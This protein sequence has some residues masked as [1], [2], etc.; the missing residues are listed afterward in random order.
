MNK[1]KLHLPKRV[2]RSK[3]VVKRLEHGEGGGGGGG[4]GEFLGSGLVVWGGWI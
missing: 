3:H 2:L 1:I 4:G